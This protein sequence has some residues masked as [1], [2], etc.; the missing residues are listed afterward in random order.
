M[1]YEYLIINRKEVNKK[2]EKKN[3]WGKRV[4]IEEFNHWG[5]DL[6]ESGWRFVAMIGITSMIFEKTIE[7]YPT[8]TVKDLE[9][10]ATKQVILNN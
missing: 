2:I 6:P 3:I 8:F 7:E 5:W 9:S 4:E 1:K 10:S